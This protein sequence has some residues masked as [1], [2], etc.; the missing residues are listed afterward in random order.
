MNRFFG[1]GGGSSVLSTAQ[2]SGIFSC[3]ASWR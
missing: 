1:V 2:P 3:G